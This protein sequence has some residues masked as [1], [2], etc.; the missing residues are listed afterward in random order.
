[1]IGRTL[2]QYRILEKL[3]EGGMGAVYVAEDTELHR[4]VALKVLP[5][6]MADYPD[7]LRR[8]KQE[9]RAVAALNHP[10]I[11]TV[12]SVE[13]AE[14]LHFITMELVR[15]RPLTDL[16]SGDGL[17]AERLLELAVPLADAVAA[18]HKRG[19]V[20]RDLKPDNVMLDEEGR[21]KVL[22]FGLAKL[23]PAEQAGTDTTVAAEAT[24]TAEGSILGTVAYMSPE[25]AQG[26][27]VDSRSDVFSLGILLYE[28]ATGRR[29]FHGDNNLSILT[30]I[31]RDTP[32]SIV[33]SAP[34]LPRPLDEIVRRCLRKDPE[35]R[36]AHAGDLKKDLD[37]LRSDIISGVSSPAV[38]AAAPGRRTS[39]RRLWWSAA[40][41]AVVA[42]VAT[43]VIW[44]MRRNARIN[45]ARTVAIPRI[46][47]LKDQ[48]SWLEWGTNAWE[49][50]ELAAE[51][52]R[53]IGEDPLLA[54][55]WKTVASDTVIKSDP[56]G[57]DVWAKAYTDLLGEWRH[58]GRTPLDPVRFPLGASRVKLELAGHRTAYDLL[59]N[60]RFTEELT[61]RLQ[62]EG[63]LPEG[64]IWVPGGKHALYLPGIDHLEAEPTRD[65]LMDR[66]EVSN[67]EFKAFIK[68]EGYQKPEYWPSPLI[69]DGRTLTWD[70]AMTHFRDATDRPGPS[71]WEVGDYPKGHDDYPVSGISWYE[72]AAYAKWARKSLP[73][74]FH[75]NQ[76]ALTWAAGEII[77]LSNFGG[78]G[79]AP[80]RRH[81]GM[82]RHGAFDLAGNVREWCQNGTTRGD[83]RFILG[84]GWNDP[85]Y[86]FNDA[87]AQSPWDRTPTNG[88]R[89]IR[90]LEAEDETA[91]LT[92]T[93][94][95]PF[96]DFYNE[97]PASDE[98][99]AI[100]LKQYDYDP[101]PLNASIDAEQDH[102]DWTRET[103]TFDAA[104][105]D[106][107]M[108]AYLFL[109]KGGT[110]PL[111]TVVYFPGSGAIHTDSSD[112][113]DGRWF[114]FLLKSG[115]AV[116]LPIYKGTFERGD[117][118]DSD[119]PEETNFYKEHVIMW[120]K[121]LGRSVDYLETRDDLDTDKLAFYGVSWGGILG[122]ILPAIE[123]RIQVNVL[124]VAGLLFQR[125]LPEVDQINYVSRVEQPTLM[126]NGEFDFF[127]PVETSQKPLY[128]LLGAAEEDKRYVV[129]PGSHSVP[130][131]ELYREVLDWLD[132]YAAVEE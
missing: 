9:A 25:Q 85:G 3:G 27:A 102:D 122:S 44:N 14:G 5:P 43:L 124:Y 48:G 74:L 106:E 108:M 107:R 77:P 90:Y 131:T 123:R 30:S 64:M 12:F 67:C 88:F 98:T 120:A 128:D 84:G 82:H 22:D 60:T 117:E 47:E 121:D 20:H 109:P 92:R 59:L 129:Y 2:S 17:G 113:V 31:L 52:A 13:E 87:Y 99:F 18:A 65:F 132:R 4:Q 69:K 94:E 61:Y 70:E 57:A 79:P 100:W 42:L 34:R 103:I 78:E 11:V 10:N 119:Y 101:T 40:A 63:S 118:L 46:F 58:L 86:A 93:I 21:L 89:C 72:A 19:I 97:E 62:P 15:G 54:T 49:A 116:M 6:E 45:W 23:G 112:H 83:Q 33:D 66:F 1:M 80:A 111:Q 91:A 26:K 32:Q 125:A 130:R 81:Q 36:Y 76:V 50:H 95:M 114:D 115:R 41:L 39:A 126:I 7:R 73:T 51:A 55:A 35:K 24:V 68:S 75:W 28:M 104:Y 38:P 110:R 56:P 71:T 8:F 96:R 53:A 105:G 29:P 127:F 37:R 16:I